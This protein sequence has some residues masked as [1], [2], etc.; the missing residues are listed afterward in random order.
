MMEFDFIDFG[1]HRYFLISGCISYRIA[2]AIY[3]DVTIAVYLVVNEATCGIW[4]LCEVKTRKKQ[5]NEMVK[6]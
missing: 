3:R 2:V 4:L 1:C 5:L 6:A